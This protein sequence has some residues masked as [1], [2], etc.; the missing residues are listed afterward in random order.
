MDSVKQ[1]T[2]ELQAQEH[3]PEPS[4]DRTSY[5]VFPSLTTYQQQNRSPGV[6][7]A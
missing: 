6:V 2:P 5:R 3:Q 1:K 7:R 4:Q